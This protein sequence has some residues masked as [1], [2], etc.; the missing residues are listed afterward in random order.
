MRYR[1]DLSADYAHSLL[2]Y[3]M[4]AGELIWKY[5]HH[6]RAQWN[7][8]FAGKP[9]GHRDKSGYTKLRIDGR[10]YFRH[11]VIWLLMTGN[12]P[13]GEIDHIDRNP[14]NDAWNNLRIA[15]PSQNSSNQKVRTNKTSSYKGVWWNKRNG[16]W[17]AAIQS[18]N[19][20]YHIGY[21][22]T[23]ELAYAAYCKESRRL[24]G[25]WGFIPE[26]QPIQDCP[27]LT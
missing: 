27:I 6:K 14:T 16:K 5:Q 2:K 3:D 18:N 23:E 24:H 20:S 11:R 10:L 7:G 25:I 15:T 17:A 26:P 4:I 22:A 8:R 12:T 9:A 21:F 13:D 1:D 19:V